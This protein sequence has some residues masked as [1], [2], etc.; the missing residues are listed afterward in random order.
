VSPIYVSFHAGPGYAEEAAQ[1][2]ATLDALGL[3]SDIRER[4]DAGSWARNCGQKP[5]YIRECLLR[6]DRPVVWLDADARVKRLPAFPACDFAAHWRTGVELLSGTLYFGNSLQALWLLDLWA[7]EQAMHPEEWDQRTLQRVVDRKSIP[8]MNIQ[9]LPVE[10]C[11]VF[12]GR[13]CPADP[14]ILHTQVSRRLRR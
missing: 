12:D 2:K 14:I 10:C 8:R 13:D 5:A 3:E 9:R 7:E 6:H 1:L 4:A 11:A